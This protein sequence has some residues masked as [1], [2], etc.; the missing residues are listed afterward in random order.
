MIARLFFG[1]LDFD[2]LN[3][4][5]LIRRLNDFFHVSHVATQN[6]ANGFDG[7]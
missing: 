6:R 7:M 3:A 5:R 2:N 4:Y 1:G